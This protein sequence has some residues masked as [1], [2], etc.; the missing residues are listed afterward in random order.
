MTLVYENNAAGP[1]THALIVGVGSYPFAKPAHEREDTPDPLKDV[2]D[3][4]SAAAG[5]AAFCDWLIGEAKPPS[6][7]LTV[8]LLTN[9]TEAL[10]STYTWTGRLAAPGAD[11][12]GTGDVEAPTTA[13]LQA[14]GERWRERLKA[15]PGS[16]GIFYICG[17]GSI[18]ASDAM[19]FLADLNEDEQG[20]WDARISVTLLANALK[21]LDQISAAHL[22]V[23]ACGEV[24]PELALEPL[25][26][27]VKFLR[28]NP[29]KGG[30]QKVSLLAAAAPNYL[31]YEDTPATGGRFTLTVLRGLRGASARDLDGDAHWAT[32]PQWIYEDLKGLYALRPDW[33][34]PLEPGNPLL[35]SEEK[36]IVLYDSA[37]EVVLRL[38]LVPEEA[39]DQCDLAVL[40]A[41]KTLPPLHQKA[42]DGGPHWV[43][44][45]RASKD[46]HFIK[47]EFQNGSPYLAKEQG[48]VPDRSWLAKK[49][50]VQP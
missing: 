22:I 44:P 23:D 24:I 10:H 29:F 6:P 32:L 34:D 40:D 3:L 17:H 48:F 25:S 16:V 30:T 45:M 37:P 26:A 11:P 39:I 9:G 15:D 50:K 7:L 41:G 4:P 14:A 20:P 42:A 12:R 38:S 33:T 13:A 49:L 46:P 31:A 35:P 43:L 18:L 21:Q 28:P 36:P 19:V 2:A 47:A 1:G 5:A 27:G 8:E